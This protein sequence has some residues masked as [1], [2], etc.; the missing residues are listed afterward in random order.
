MM[1][2]EEGKVGLDDEV[3]K[4]LP[5]FKSPQVISRLD[6]EAGIYE[7]RPA[8]RPIT[9]RQLLTHTSGIDYSW[10]DPGLAM[11]EKLT[12]RTS[13]ADLPLVHEPGEKW[14]YGASTKV[15]GDVVETL[16]GQRLDTFFESRIFRPLKM[17]DT[18][19]TV[20]QDQ[21]DRVVT[22]HQRTNDRL[23]ENPEPGDHRRPTA[24]RRTPFRRRPT[25]AGS[26]R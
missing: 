15:L 1:L 22:L 20:P 21:N 25:T 12:G 5:A 18:A 11:I 9:I 14:T 23:T 17:Y 24:R 3:S 19:W 6:P 8:T 26:C 13:E 2:V 16:S 10:S 4:N 7:I